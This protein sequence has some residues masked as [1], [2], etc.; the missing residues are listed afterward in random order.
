MITPRTWGFRACQEIGSFLVTVMKSPPKKTR[1]TPGSANNAVA[2]GLRVAEAGEAKSAVERPSTSRPG[3]NFNVAGFGV[4]S[5]SMN[6]AMPV[7]LWGNP[8]LTVRSS[9]DTSVQTGGL[10]RGTSVRGDRYPAEPRGVRIGAHRPSRTVQKSLG[11][12]RRSRQSFS[13]CHCTPTAYPRQ[14]LLTGGDTHRFD[15]AVRGHT[16]DRQARGELVD[17]LVVQRV[18]RDLRRAGQPMQPAAGVTRTAWALPWRTFAEG[19]SGVE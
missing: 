19:C 10:T 1:A 15:R 12:A 5:V 17:A 7:L 4:P 11:T 6:M 8:D 13:G 2:R 16:F 14:G 3:R 9:D 18:D